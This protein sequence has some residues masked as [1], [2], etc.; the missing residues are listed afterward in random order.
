MVTTKEIEITK[1]MKSTIYTNTPTGTK[2][3]DIVM[4]SQVVDTI[5]ELISSRRRC[6]CLF[7]TISDYL[8]TTKGTN[9]MSMSPIDVVGYIKDWDEE[10]NELVIMLDGKFGEEGGDYYISPE[11]LDRYELRYRSL[12]HL[13]H[14]PKAKSGNN[15]E[16]SMKSLV[17]FDL[18]KS[19]TLEARETIK[20]SKEN[21]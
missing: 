10:T 18:V 6:I 3:V 15:L 9:Y 13:H 17:G 20:E 1:K 19:N 14:N 5:R 12:M 21:K 4:S 11:E 2:E 8:Y 16:A 7:D